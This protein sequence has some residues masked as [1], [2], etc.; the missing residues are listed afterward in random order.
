MCKTDV[1]RRI[2]RLEDALDRFDGV[3]WIIR[4]GEIARLK[5][6]VL[7][8]S[9]EAAERCA[10]QIDTRDLARIDR[11]IDEATKQGGSATRAQA[12]FAK[13]CTGL[14][15]WLAAEAPGQRRGE[16]GFRSFAGKAVKREPAP[17]V[18]PADGTW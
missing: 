17:P 7:Y 12:A 6:I 1:E 10:A 18:R 11:A 8:M 9:G 3:Q 4:V 14:Q 16:G 5:D 2:R 13:A 15:Q